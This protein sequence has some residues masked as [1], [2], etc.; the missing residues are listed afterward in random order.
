MA[1]KLSIKD[2]TAQLKD[3]KNKQINLL[4]KEIQNQKRSARFIS[5]IMILVLMASSLGVVQYFQL[6]KAIGEKEEQI[7]HEKILIT[8]LNKKK[9]NISMLKGH[10]QR[11]EV[12]DKVLTSLYIANHSPSMVFKLLENSTP[13]D[14]TYMSIQFASANQVS[15]NG[16]S[17][18]ENAI[19]DFIYNLKRVTV[20]KDK[21]YT[22]VF[23]SNISKV[24][25][26]NSRTEFQFNIQ[27][28]FGGSTNEKE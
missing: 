26:E 18:S 10:V 2:K 13:K 3:F 12:K 9:S 1:F 7:A 24:V 20:D 15:I 19:A 14:I 27:C 17:N 21:F 5:L 8:A 11:I 16:V 28:K 25:I 4:P 23:V 6:K 22:D